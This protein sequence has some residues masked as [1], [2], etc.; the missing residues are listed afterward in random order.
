[1]KNLLL[2]LVGAGAAVG[3]MLAL[4]TTESQTTTTKATRVLTPRER[5]R[6]LLDNED[7][8]RR[9]RE[10]IAELEARLAKDAD[11]E[12]ALLYP[13]DTPEKVG[14]LLTAAYADNNI[15]WLLQ[16]IERLLM[17]GERGY[18]MLRTIIMDI[19]FKAKFRPS[20]ERLPVR[21][22]LQGRQ[23]L[24]E[25]REEVHRLPELPAH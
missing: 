18:P 19:I 5:D 12:A 2:L 9:L 17:M 15:D 20:A 14:V 8:I 23:H 3:A 7:L 6:V 11:V 13:D 21:P 10:R 4:E 1:M 22:D 25:A 16:V 24:H